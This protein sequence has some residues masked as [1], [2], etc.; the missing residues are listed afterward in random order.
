MVNK[1][2]AMGRDEWRELPMEEQMGFRIPI[3]LVLDLPRLRERGPVITALDYLRLH[4][5]GP[6]V[7]STSGWWPKGLYH[8]S[9]NVFESDKTKMPSLFIIENHLYD[10]DGTNRVDYITEEMKVR[11]NRTQGGPTEIST[12]LRGIVSDR[13]IVVDWE[14]AKNTLKLSELVP[15]VDLDNDAAFEDILNANGWE[16]LYT[17]SHLWVSL[18]SF[19]VMSKLIHVLLSIS[20][21]ELDRTVVSPIKQVTPRWTIR[22][23]KDDYYDVDED[24]VLLAG[25][26]HLSRKVVSKPLR[27][28][29]RLILVKT[30][31]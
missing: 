14:N 28:P 31:P 5:Q 19:Y 21:V 18:L 23:F 15:E 27:S 17:F 8:R 16:V 12:L 7:E 13:S 29:A 25:E 22:G 1:G 30:S 6:E 10:P 4:G 11:R 20:G 2:D 26:T 24:V 9:P 3:S